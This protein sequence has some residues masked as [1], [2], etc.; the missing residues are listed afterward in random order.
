MT[1][2]NGVKILLTGGGSGGSVSPLLAVAEAIKKEQPHAKFLFV[3]GKIGPEQKMAAAAGLDFVSIPAGKFRR[4]FSLKNFVSPFF[5]IAGFFEAKKIIKDFKPDAVFGT[6]SFVQ[7]PVVWA[8]YFAG[9][10][11][12]LHQQDIVPSLA[13][14]LCQIPAG[15]ITVTFE[16]SLTDFQNGV[17]LFYKKLKDKVVLTGNPFRKDLANFTK[18]D[19]EKFFNLKKELPTLLVLG[20]GTGSEALN[21]VIITALPELTK[22][23]Q[24][25][26]IAGSGKSLSEVRPNYF[27]ME[28]TASM[29]E[30]YAA[31]DIV[32][33]RCGLS[34]L[35]ELSNLKKVSIL[36]PMPKSHQQLNAWLMH[37]LGA[38]IVIEQSLLTARVLNKVV[39]DLLFNLSVQKTLSSQI[40]KIMPRNSDEKIAKIIIKEITENARKF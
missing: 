14:K 30:A 19:G 27:P 37:S 13:N 11:V 26:H 21:K 32:L 16:K 28:F 31:A 29:G 1:T 36:V 18:A 23:I 33:S 4:Y 40:S 3:G 20:G 25:I 12:I 38:A 5:T 8:A 22:F 2:F 7:V 34:T 15:K 24:V 17:G 9:I 39:R 6:G 35:T 10:P